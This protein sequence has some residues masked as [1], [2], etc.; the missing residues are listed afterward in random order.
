VAVLVEQR[1]TFEPVKRAAKKGDRINL[2]LAATIDGEQVESTGPEGLN[3]VLGAD[4][5]YPEFDAQLTGGK[6]GASKTFE[7]TYPADH[8]PEHLAGKTVNYDITFNT[9]EQAN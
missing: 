1:A 5:R 8:K 6:A 9:V 4:G 2:T 7:I 3:L